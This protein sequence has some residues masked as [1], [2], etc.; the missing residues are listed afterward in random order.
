MMVNTKA[1]EIA[2]HVSRAV[3]LATGVS[4]FEWG[5]MHHASCLPALRSRCHKFY[6]AGTPLRTE[7]SMIS[8]DIVYVS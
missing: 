4:N 1:R 5:T 6:H 3:K 7:C 2:P 8:D